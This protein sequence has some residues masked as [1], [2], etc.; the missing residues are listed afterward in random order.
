MSVD[1]PS[2]SFLLLSP[3]ES[4]VALSGPFLQYQALHTIADTARNVHKYAVDT[5]NWNQRGMPSVFRAS[6]YTPHRPFK[7][8][9]SDLV[10]LCTSRLTCISYTT[11]QSA[12]QI[13]HP[14]TQTSLCTFL[15]IWWVNLLHAHSWLGVV[16]WLIHWHHLCSVLILTLQIAQEAPLTPSPPTMLLSALVSLHLMATLEALDSN[17]ATD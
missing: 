12:P 1:L 15:R 17:S 13:V 14:D 4:L 5:K 8:L 3:L 11:F 10:K 6:K 16:Q 7:T 9:V 2:P